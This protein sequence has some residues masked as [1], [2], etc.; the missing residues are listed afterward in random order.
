L[1]GFLGGGM[2]SWRQEGRD[3]ERIER[4]PLSELKGR[5]DDNPDLQVLDVRE[6]SEWNA[7]HIPASIFEPWHDIDGLTDGLDASKPVAVVCGSGQ[8]AA[9][10]A[11]LIQRFGVDEVVHVIDGGVP[12]WKRLGLP[13]EP[14]S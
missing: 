9:V 8:R 2:T 10:G 1:G 3:V 12:K 14:S 13:V 7:G 11:S 4:L 6:R 5:L